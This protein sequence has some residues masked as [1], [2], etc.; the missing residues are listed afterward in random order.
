MILRLHGSLPRSPQHAR[1]GRR[2]LRVESPA[3]SAGARDP[4]LRV[5][6]ENVSGR[7]G[8]ADEHGSLAARAAEEEPAARHLDGRGG[9]KSLRQVRLLLR[10]AGAELVGALMFLN[11]IASPLVR[12]DPSS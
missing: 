11:R 9:L 3:P 12:T 10:R 8:E 1:K 6:P 7:A 4:A 5:P 2:A